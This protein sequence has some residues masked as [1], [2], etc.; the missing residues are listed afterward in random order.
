M[1]TVMLMMSA[2]SS[3]GVLLLLLS[4]AFLQNCPTIHCG[5]SKHV[6]V[7]T[8]QRGVPDHVVH[9][10]KEVYKNTEHEIWSLTSSDIDQSVEQSLG[11]AHPASCTG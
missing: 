4:E 3:Q 2:S 9:I 5:R 6:F 1:V 7:G 8:T 11:A 10:K